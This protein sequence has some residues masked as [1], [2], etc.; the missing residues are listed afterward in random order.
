MGVVEHIS[1]RVAVMYLGRI[2]ELAERHDL[3]RKQEHPYTS[4]LMSAIPIPDPE[5]RRQR[6][7]L[8]GDVP[9]PVNPPTGCRFHPR[10]PLRAELGNPD[11]CAEQVPAL[12]D[13]AGGHL[14]ACHFRTP[15]TSTEPPELR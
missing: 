3:F 6:V 15:A 1:D 7:I 4:A 8:T 14:V 13:L 12:L 11:I 5:M 2:A 9:S 10:C